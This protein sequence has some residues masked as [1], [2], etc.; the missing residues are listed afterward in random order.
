MYHLAIETEIS[1]A[2]QLRNYDGPCARPHGHNWKIRLNVKSKQ[3]D[4]VG[5]AIDFAELEKIT[6]QVVGPF[7]HNDFNRIKPFDTINPTAENIAKYFFD[8]IMLKLPQDVTLNSIEIWE[9]DKYRV[10]YAPQT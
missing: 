9:T 1:S 5:M 8:Q 2:H 6:W 4:A 7:D 3:L 10:S